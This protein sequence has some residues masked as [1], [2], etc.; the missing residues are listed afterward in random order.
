MLDGRGQ[1][2]VTDFGLAG[3]ADQIQGAEVRS[4]TPAYMAPEQLAGKEVTT[5]S[6]IYALG[7][8]LYEVFTGK[9]VFG[10][11]SSGTRGHGESTPSRPSSVVRDL[12]P[13]VD[14]VILRCLETEPG[15]RPATVLAVARRCPAVIHWRQHL[16]LV[17]HRRRN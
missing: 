6:D 16:R 3:V 1:V 9:R 11:K 15:A 10:E 8:V 2:V 7:L 13:I 17:R 5:R 12:D 14:R 4:G